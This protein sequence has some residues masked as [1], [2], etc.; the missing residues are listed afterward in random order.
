MILR[1]SLT[2]LSLTLLTVALFS[3]TLLLFRSFV[4]HRTDLGK[5]WS[6][7]GRAALASGHPELAIDSLRTAL[8][9]APGEHAYELLLAQAL[10]RAGHTEEAYNYF[11]GLW[12]AEPGSGLINLQLARLAAEKKEEQTA[13]NFYRASIYGTWEGDGVTRRRDVRLE[14]ARYLLQHGDRSAAR[15]E[16][17]VAEGNADNDPALDTEL[18][19]LFEQAGDRAEALDAYL[20][21][22]QA[23]PK[24]A[25]PLEAAGQ[26]SFGMGQFAAAQHLLQQ[27]Y[28][29]DANSGRHLDQ[30]SGLRDTLRRTDRILELLPSRRLAPEERVRRIL[31]LRN[32][33][34]NRLDACTAG[35]ST[36]PSPLEAIN[37]RWQ[38][39]V[40]TT[41]R[42]SLIRDPSRQDDLLQ[43][44]FD[45]ENKA[46]EVCGPATG[47]D[48]LIVLL[49]RDPKA[50]DRQ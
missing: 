44:I 39:S 36:S 49:S 42:T 45:T 4:S 5:R 23:D 30:Q 3:V 37:G 47:D 48:A 16:L 40:K 14:L 43:L 35:S 15:V 12:D 17:L 10:A 25:A 29:I 18:G 1:D 22:S 33:A 50:M 28:R 31:A 26:L 11:S 8:S 27:A 32:L 46:N 13:V 9:Y 34:K 2:F 21:A 6:D 41:N 20:K 7:R 19:R 24:S 38:S